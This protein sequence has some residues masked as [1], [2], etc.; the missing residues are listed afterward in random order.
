MTKILVIGVGQIGYNNAEYMTSKGFEVDGFDISEEAIQRA[1]KNN[2]IKKQCKS[3]SEYDVY[4]VCVST[5][6]TNNMSIPDFK[7]LYAVAERIDEE[8]RQ[9]TLICIDSTVTDRAIN[10][11]VKICGH[12]RHIVHCPHRFYEQEKEEHGV[13]QLRVIGGVR[14]CC[15]EKGIEFYSG[16]LGIKLHPVSSI[17]MA[18]LTKQMENAHRF[19]NIAFVEEWSMICERLNISFDELRDAVN[20]KWN[21]KLL[22]PLDGIGGHCLP[23]DTEMLVQVETEN[24]GGILKAAQKADYDYKLFRHLHKV[25]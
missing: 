11:F 22:K 18:A 14:V 23:K 6:N 19:L 21:T 20:T 8:A 7:S 2:V 13:N 25:G 1:I 3:F 24:N 15:V 9:D 17:Y 12:N 4:V 5:H 10:E 16:K